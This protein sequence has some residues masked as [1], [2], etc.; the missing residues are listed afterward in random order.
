MTTAWLFPKDVCSRK[1]SLRA[2]VVRRVSTHLAPAVCQAAGYSQRDGTAS[3]PPRRA[4][5]ATRKMDR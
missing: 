1:V 4:V 5:R 3:Q 2:Y